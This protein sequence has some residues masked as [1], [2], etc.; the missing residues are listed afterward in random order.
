MT[1]LNA[2]KKYWYLVVLLIVVSTVLSFGISLFQTPKY[3]SEVNLL[4]IQKQGSK[5]DAYS[6]ARSAETISGVLSKM[7]YTTSFY[8]RVQKVDYDLGY[9]LP[10]SPEKRKKE[11]EKMVRTNASGDGTMSIEVYHP[12]REV[13]E[14]YAMGIAYVL[15]NHGWDYHGGGDQIEIKMV[16][17][18]YTSIKPASPN[19]VQNTVLGLMAGTMISLSMIMLLSFRKQEE[20]IFVQA[21]DN[22][23]ESLFDEDNNSPKTLIPETERA[24]LP[25]RIPILESV[26]SD[27]LEDN[28]ETSVQE[29]LPSEEKRE[30]TEEITNLPVEDK[31]D[32]VDQEIKTKKGPLPEELKRSGQKDHY[33]PASVNSWVRSGKF[34]PQQS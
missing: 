31:S 29:N 6:A 34:D 22:K 20:D 26:P 32:E 3:L 9:A 16:D 12:N 1:Y 33:H 8:D 18:P 14:N 13:A 2:L 5:L 25:E 4:V 21:E 27:E 11:W 30:A 7:V 10:N 28:V 15:V 19:L 17:Q 23:G 24:D